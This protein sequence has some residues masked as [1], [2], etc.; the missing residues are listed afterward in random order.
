M[1][2][3]AQ[4]AF[5]FLMVANILLVIAIAGVLLWSLAL[6]EPQLGEVLRVR[7]PPVA[8]FALPVRQ[9][10]A[11][12]LVLLPMLVAAQL[13]FGQLLAMLRSVAAGEPFTTVNADRLVR[14]GW[15]LLTIQLLDLLFA[16]V[17]FEVEVQR[18]NSVSGW[19]PSLTGWLAVLVAFVLARVF[20]EGTRLRS[21]AELTI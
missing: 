18:G 16:T 11:V 21:E 8:D 2:R 7:F 14:I 17:V 10:Q 15:A 6:D 13:I 1:L 3:F 20:R 19:E 9:G 12:L 5:R 4:G